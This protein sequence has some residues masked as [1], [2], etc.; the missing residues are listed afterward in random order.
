MKTKTDAMLEPATH[1]LQVY[2]STDWAT[3]KV[4]MKIIDQTSFSLFISKGSTS[5]NGCVLFPLKVQCDVK[6][7]LGG[8]LNSLYSCKYNALFMVMN[9]CDFWN[10]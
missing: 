8:I 1:K 10:L 7:Q 9:T 3:R 5:H 4:Q 2:P 6:Y